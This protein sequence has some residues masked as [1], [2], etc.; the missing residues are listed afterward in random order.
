MWDE[1]KDIVGSAAPLVGSLLGGPLGGSVGTLIADKLGVK[2]DASEILNKLKT[3]PE[4]LVKIKQM[5]SDERQQL[6]QLKFEEAK[7]KSEERKHEHQTTQETIQTGDTAEDKYVRR[8]RPKMARL[9]FYFGTLY[10]LVMEAATLWDIGDGANPVL[11]GTLYGPAFTYLGMRTV[12]AFS[13]YKG[14]KMGGLVKQV[15]NAGK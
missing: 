3:D 1:I 9:S 11:L 5:E 15:T 8:T 6:R 12:D 14:P 7:L 13:K 4:S 10:A 2:D